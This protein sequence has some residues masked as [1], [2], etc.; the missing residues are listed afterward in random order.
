MNIISAS[1]RTDLPARYGAWFMNRIDAGFADY[2]NPFGGQ[3]HRVDLRPEEVA[4]FVF[5]TK[6]ALDFTSTL[7]WLLARSYKAYFQYT[8]TGFGKPLEPGVPPAPRVVKNFKEISDLLGPSFV[9]WRYDPI[10][11]APGFENDFHLKNFESLAR[12]LKGFTRVC[13]IS[14]VQFYRK[15]DRRIKNLIEEQGLLVRDPEPEEKIELATR[16][17]GIAESY[18]IRLV[19][20]CMPILTEAG[21]PAGSCVDV[22]L[23]RKLRPDLS[24]PSFKPRPSREGCRCVES[25]DIGAYDTCLGG[26]VYC[27]ATQNPAIAQR[28]ADEHDPEGERM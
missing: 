5:W 27:Y 14:F 10:V 13:H 7:R 17:S 16:L 12:R 8:L 19:S 26:C 3:I 24:E 1:R 11:M 25:R 2:R 22:D 18:G 28:R 4:A 15:T 9:R 6:N 21:I 23:I 20:C